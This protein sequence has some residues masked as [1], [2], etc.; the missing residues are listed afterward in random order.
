MCEIKCGV[1]PRAICILTVAEIL[2]QR[3]SGLIVAYET[4]E[5]KLVWPESFRDRESFKDKGLSAHESNMVDQAPP[6]L[7]CIVA[8]VWGRTGQSSPHHGTPGK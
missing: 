3:K 8:G 5:N 6:F 1:P 7:A 4:I 2:S